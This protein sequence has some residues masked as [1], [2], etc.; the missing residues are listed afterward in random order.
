VDHNELVRLDA[1]E[2]AS[3][4][5]RGEVSPL[6]LVDAAIMRIDA[7]IPRLNAVIHRFYDEARRQARGDLPPGPFLANPE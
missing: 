5:R 4:V 6:E 7:L 3:L 1:T 2:Q